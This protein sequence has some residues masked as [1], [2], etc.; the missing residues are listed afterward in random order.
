MMAKVRSHSPV[1]GLRQFS[2]S[3]ARPKGGV[4]LHCDGIGLLGPCALNGPPFE[5]TIDRNDAASLG[6]GV[7]ERR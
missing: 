2:H 5:E 3:P 4:V 1:F 6:I 7:A